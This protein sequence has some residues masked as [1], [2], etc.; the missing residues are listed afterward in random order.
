M[1]ITKY[2]IS[3]TQYLKINPEECIHKDECQFCARM[4]IDYIDEKNNINIKF[5][6]EDASD[7]YNFLVKSKRVQKLLKGILS[8]PNN[9]INDLGFEYNQF[10]EGKQEFND[11]FLEHL[12]F[13]NS[14]KR[15]YYDSWLYNDEDGNIIL[16]ITPFYPWF[17][18]TKK[19]NPEKIS[20][21][22][23][24]KDYKPVVK[25]IIP[26][27]SLKQWIKQADE[28]GKKYKLKFE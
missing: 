22:E 25:T 11:A 6:Y 28:F 9:I 8:L 27:E 13:S 2:K 4:D 21:K 18:V 24:I 7:F 26:K 20:Y 19:T 14:S 3:N 16:E 17:N 10:T 12:W 15:P 23:W 1:N 5:G